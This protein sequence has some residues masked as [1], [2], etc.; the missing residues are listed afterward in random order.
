M[1]VNVTLLPVVTELGL[2]EQETERPVVFNENLA[3]TVVGEDIGKT[4]VSPVVVVV[5]AGAG[6]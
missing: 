6:Q 5:V 4:Q 1:A 3:I 2:A